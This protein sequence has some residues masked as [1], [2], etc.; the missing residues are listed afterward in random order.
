MRTAI[1]SGVIL[2]VVV[3]D[4]KHADASEIALRRVASEGAL[5]VGECVLAEIRPAFSNDDFEQFLD[6]WNI[7]FEPS[8][9]ESS[10][11]AG[12]MFQVYLRR[13]RAVSRRVVAD[14][15]I[16]AHALVTCD[17]LLARDRGYYRDYFA[18][19][20]IIEP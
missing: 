9:R 15:L 11:L 6:D 18:G 16:G 2:D 20:R 1:D 13:R 5:V 19:L 4:P 8:S 14:F 12:A 17:R 3:G 10:L 7:V